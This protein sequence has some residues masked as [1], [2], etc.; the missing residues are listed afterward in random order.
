M[1]CDVARVVV[2]ELVK[3]SDCHTLLTLAHIMYCGRGKTF[4]KFFHKKMYPGKPF[5]GL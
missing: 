3:A 1:A 5:K 4:M 2:S